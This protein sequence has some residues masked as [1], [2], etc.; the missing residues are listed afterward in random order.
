MGKDKTLGRIEIDI[1]TLSGPLKAKWLPLQVETSS[2][3]QLCKQFQNILMHLLIPRPHSSLIS[4]PSVLKLHFSFSI[5]LP[6]TSLYPGI[7]GSLLTPIMDHYT[8]HS[9]VIIAPRSCFIYYSI[10]LSSH[11]LPLNS[12]SSFLSFCSLLLSSHALLTPYSSLATHY[13][14]SFP[15]PS[16]LSSHSCL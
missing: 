13:D 1:S 5:L 12:H 8:C 2:L 16:L 15:H 7:P 6:L 9:P 4:H 10:I 11:S 3:A 14:S